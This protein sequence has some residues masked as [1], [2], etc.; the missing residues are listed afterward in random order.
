MCERREG[1]SSLLSALVLT[2]S[3]G[4]EPADARDGRAV[5]EDDVLDQGVALELEGLGDREHDG[6]VEREE[7]GH[8]IGVR[9]KNSKIHTNYT[10]IMARL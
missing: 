6:G 8:E 3:S 1:R 10:Y 5:L 2:E 7:S 4:S 9:K